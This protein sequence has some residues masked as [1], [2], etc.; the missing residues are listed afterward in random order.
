MGLPEYYLQVRKPR[1]MPREN[2]KANRGPYE[3]AHKDVSIVIH[4]Q[5]HNH[6]RNAQLHWVDACA[7]GLLGY[8]DDMT[9][10]FQ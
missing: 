6:I 2:E 7:N 9:R 4:G 8:N 3:D 5:Q 1:R 10:S